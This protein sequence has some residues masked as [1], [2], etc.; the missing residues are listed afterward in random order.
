MLRISERV[1]AAGKFAQD[2]QAGRFSK[3]QWKISK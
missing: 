2:K 3:G 1:L